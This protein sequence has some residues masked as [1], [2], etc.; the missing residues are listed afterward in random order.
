MVI[1]FPTPLWEKHGRFGPSKWRRG[2]NAETQKL[3]PG[4]GPET[5]PSLLCD[6]TSEHLK[7]SCS[8]WSPSL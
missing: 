2:N 7:E 6:A 1:E 5:L 8:L 4:R 3:R